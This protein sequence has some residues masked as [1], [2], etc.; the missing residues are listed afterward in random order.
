MTD[1]ITLRKQ[2]DRKYPSITQIQQ[3]KAE[4]VEML[5]TLKE[6]HVLGTPLTDAQWIQLN[7][8]IDKH[9]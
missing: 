8:L 9:K 2:A 6:K 7:G 5:V 1:I 4:L 3:D